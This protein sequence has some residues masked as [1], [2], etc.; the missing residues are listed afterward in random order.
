MIARYLSAISARISAFEFALVS[1]IWGS[2]WLVIKGQLGVVPAPWSVAYR[3]TLACTLMAVFTIATG[4]WVRMTRGGHAFAAIAG[5]AQFALNF[6]LV[7]ASERH[8]TSGLIALVFAL[9]VVP[10]ALLSRIVLKTPISLRFLIG[11]AIGIIGLGLVVADDRHDPA[12]WSTTLDGLL[13]AGGAVLCASTANVMQAGG[14]ARSLA[15][16]PTLT[17]MMFYGA[18]GD[19]AFAAATSGPPVLDFRAEYAIGLIYLAFA[20]SVVAF[21][22]YY[23]LIRR[24]GPG[25]AAYSSVIVPIVA[26]TLS[27]VFEGYRWSFIS[28][29]GAALALTGLVVALGSRRN[30]IPVPAATR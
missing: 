22:V 5:T 19:I 20:A 9:L 15:P 24:I 23:R 11:S 1:L 25:P 16:F 3:F 21:T 30:K 28:A 18:L 14:F 6:N 13:L 8:V 4:R 12:E 10:N 17:W 7:Y 29:A 2:T 26:M 27:T